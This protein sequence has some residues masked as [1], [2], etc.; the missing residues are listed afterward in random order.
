[1]HGYTLFVLDRKNP[2]RNNLIEK[3][4]SVINKTMEQLQK[5]VHKFAAYEAGHEMCAKCHQSFSWNI[6]MF[7]DL[8]PNAIYNISCN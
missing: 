5:I 2:N 3:H 7:F 8:I 1:M 6:D 4:Q